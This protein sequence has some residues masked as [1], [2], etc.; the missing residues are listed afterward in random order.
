MPVASPRVW[1]RVAHGWNIRKWCQWW[2]RLDVSTPF[3]VGMRVVG[4]CVLVLAHCW[5]LEQ[6]APCISL[7]CGVLL[8]LLP[9]E[10]LPWL[11]CVEWGEGCC[12]RT[13]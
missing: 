6:Q 12:L 1:W 11:G 2:C 8:F 3:G 13:V 4:G 10:A 9:C 5:V 7:G